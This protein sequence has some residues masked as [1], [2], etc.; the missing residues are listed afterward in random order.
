MTLKGNGTGP[1]W[2]FLRRDFGGRISSAKGHNFGAL[3]IVFQ[4]ELSGSQKALWIE[5]L[6]V[7]KIKWIANVMAKWLLV[8]GLVMIVIP[9]IEH[10]VGESL[11]R[12]LHLR[13]TKV[14]GVT[15]VN[16]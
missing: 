2:H 12:H 10:F 3:G 13:F 8:A 7:R 9:F 11:D 1:I 16:V 6:D 4:L 5:V 14:L 15:R